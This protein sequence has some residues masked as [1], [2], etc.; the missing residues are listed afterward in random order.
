M[1]QEIL[2]TVAESQFLYIH[3]ETNVIGTKVAVKM[4]PHMFTS[5]TGT[6]YAIA[7]YPLAG[8]R[9]RLIAL[10]VIIQFT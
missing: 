4:I 1:T 7:R 9:Q 2:K 6:W 5:I 3:I 8:D 10:T